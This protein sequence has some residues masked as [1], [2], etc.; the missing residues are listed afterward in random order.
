MRVTFWKNGEKI[1]FD[2]ATHDYIN[3]QKCIQNGSEIDKSLDVD[4]VILQQYIH[5][6]REK[7]VTQTIEQEE[8]DYSCDYSDQTL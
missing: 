2:I 1:G 6:E 4:T 7:I 5:S 8:G 3:L